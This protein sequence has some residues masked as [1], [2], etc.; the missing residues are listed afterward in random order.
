MHLEWLITH[1]T[2]VVI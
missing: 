2:T 1:A